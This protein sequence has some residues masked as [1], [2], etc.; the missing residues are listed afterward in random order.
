MFFQSLVKVSPIDK[1]AVVVVVV[2][3]RVDQ[4]RLTSTSQIVVVVVVLVRVNQ[5]RLPSTPVFTFFR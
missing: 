3:V 4:R 5:S 1:V 2:L